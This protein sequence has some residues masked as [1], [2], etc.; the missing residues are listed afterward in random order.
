MDFHLCS[1]KLYDRIYVGDSV[2]LIKKVPSD[3]IDLVVTSPPYLFKREKVFGHN[4]S[5]TEYVDWLFSLSEEFMRVL[6][7]T[8][9]FVLNI[10]EGVTEGRKEPYVLKYL[11]K[12]SDNGYWR[13]TYIWAKTNPYP[14]GN[15]KRLKDGFE[16]C[17]HFTKTPDYRFFPNNCLV[18]ANQKWLKDNLKRKNKG[19]HN[20]NN[21]SGL[22]MAIRTC[23]TMARPSNV[24]TL[25]T[26]TTN[27]KHPATF[28][29][30]LPQFFIKL[31]TKKDDLVLDP[32]MGSGTTAIACLEEDRNFLGFDSK[33]EYVEMAIDRVG[34][35]EEK[36]KAAIRLADVYTDS[37]T[38]WKKL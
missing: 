25:P 5:C 28:P 16:Y 23:A 26:N 33:E 12:M 14:T 21:E 11:L 19:T 9:S 10:K 32:F 34:E 4:L 31:M 8:G 29:I 13:D 6:K 17:Y 36:K 30:G 22:N 38:L 27:T 3:S 1:M 15:K 35:Y 7:K 20:V 2:E 18:P 37:D 24:I